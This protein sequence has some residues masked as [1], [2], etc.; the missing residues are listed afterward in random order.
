MVEDILYGASRHD[1]SSDNGAVCFTVPYV[2]YNPRDSVFHP[3]YGIFPVQETLSRAIDY[4]SPPSAFPR[5]LYF[6]RR[7][8]ADNDVGMGPAGSPLPQVFQS[9]KLFLP[10]N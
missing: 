7:E 3:G 9:A 8:H 1:N 4:R 10:L 2:I 5:F 6:Q